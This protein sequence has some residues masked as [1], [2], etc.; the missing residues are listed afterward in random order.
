VQAPHSA[1]RE[2]HEV[3]SAMAQVSH[4]LVERTKALADLTDSLEIQV[5]ERTAELVAEMQRREESEAKLH[6]LQRIEAIGKLTGG[7]AHDFNNMLAIIISSLE[8]MRR[9]LTRGDTDVDR[10]I[11]NAMKGAESAANLTQ[12]LLA[13]SRQQTLDPQAVDP[14]EL[15]AGMSEI[16]HRTIPETI[17]I[18]TVLA[19]GLWRTFI[20]RSGL[21]NSIVNL[22]VNARDAM[23]DGG[24]LT[25]ETA[26]THLDEAYAA[27]HA[28]VTAGQ[29]VMLALSDTGIGMSEATKARVFEPFFTT[30][31]I[32]HGTGLGL[33]QVHGFIK[34]SGGHIMIY[35]EIG[36]GTTVKLYLPR[37]TDDMPARAASSATSESIPMAQE[38][39]LVLVAEDEESVRQ[40]TVKMLEELGYTVL[41]A[42]GAE[43]ALEL[44]D[45]HPDVALLFTDVV[46]PGMN[47]RQLADEAWKRRPDLRVLFSTGYTRN[48]IVHH[49]TLD[50][51]VNL[52][53]K[54]FTLGALARKVAEVL[55]PRP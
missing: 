41:E 29:Y 1:I 42:E 7:I 30:K 55:G 46:M 39:Q 38:R 24:K 52:I 50:P 21:E 8:L 34:Q 49:G 15:V 22:A 48:A 13:F 37:L 23:P 40:G 2:V 6:Q 45:R 10:L 53:A 35:S 19:D 54:P 25:I 31:D 14:N 26:N 18:K 9:R 43:E 32:G 28:D 51:G 27:N 33:S 3:V 11:D 20:D 12:R 47:G 4:N 5:V 17:E 16:L 44:I 36:Q